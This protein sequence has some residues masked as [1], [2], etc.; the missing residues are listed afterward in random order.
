[1]RWRN[2]AGGTVTVLALAAVLAACGDDDSPLAAADKA[3]AGLDAGRMELQLSASAGTDAPTGAVGFR[4]EGPFSTAGGAG[5]GLPVLDLRY[6]NLLGGEE[7]VTRVV[8]TGEAVFVV[9]DDEVTEVPPEDAADLRLGDGSGGIAD[10]GIEGWARDA[11]VQERDDGTRVVTGKV[12]V[13]DFLSDL[14][15]IGE[16]AGGGAG[17][18]G[19]LEAAAARR[20]QEMARTSELSVEVGPDDLPRKLRAVVDFG[21]TVPE[22]LREALGPYASARLQLTLTIGRLTAPLKV[23]K[24]GA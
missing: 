13:A 9:V 22:E 20:L 24:P 2:L 23:A 1:M 3:M 16:Q 17:A 10:L 4:M 8:S 18:T 14:A 7:R 12:D 11:K 6:T 5:G 15:R 19:K 21:A